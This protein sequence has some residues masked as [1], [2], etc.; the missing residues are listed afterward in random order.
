MYTIG[1]LVNQFD[2]SRSTLL[3]YDK[4]GL[5][6]PTARTEA[7]YRLYSEAD[8]KRM[9]QIAL[10]KE[11]GLSL[12]SIAEILDS[13][14]DRLSKLLEQ[15]LESLNLEMSRVRLQQK[16]ILQLLGKESLLRKAKVMNKAQWVEILN[17][18]GM[19]ENDMRQWHIEFERSLPEVHSDFLESLGIDSA[20][21]AEIKALSQAEQRA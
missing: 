13:A 18:S 14:G 19:D 5:L 15:R 12:E 3:Y 2:I 7:N 16:L 17:A 1:Q 10:Y 11:A 6:Q 9:S 21:I 8:R 20:E 4:I